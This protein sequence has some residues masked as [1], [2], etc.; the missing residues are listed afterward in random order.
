MRLRRMAP[1]SSFIHVGTSKRLYQRRID[2][3]VNKRYPRT[4]RNPKAEP[5]PQNIL[6]LAGGQRPNE[7]MTL[8]PAS[9]FLFLVNCDEAN[10]FE[11]LLSRRCG[12]LDFVPDLTVQ[13]SSTDRRSRGDKASLCINFLAA[14]ELVFDFYV[15][16]GVQHNDTRAIAGAILRNVGEI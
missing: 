5:E 15:A 11:R 2:P 1:I 6:A 7:F 3:A 13:K 12:D 14:Y 4:E 8:R 10:Y 9:S 16:F